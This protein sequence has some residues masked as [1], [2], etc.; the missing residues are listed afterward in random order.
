MGSNDDP[1]MCC[2][3]NIIKLLCKNII[4]KWINKKVVKSLDDFHKK[5][6]GELLSKL[7]N[8]IVCSCVKVCWFVEILGVPFAQ[9][10]D[11][12]LSRPVPFTKERGATICAMCGR[13]S[14]GDRERCSQF[15][16]SFF[17]TEPLS[18]Y[19]S[20]NSLKATKQISHEKYSDQGNK[21]THSTHTRAN[22]SDLKCLQNV[23]FLDKRKTKNGP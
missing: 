16:N 11:G 12:P 2:V 1:R 14:R 22:S 17:D 3:I 20:C 10:G 5:E 18:Q 15:W 23:N 13:A 9:S 4:Y 21:K 7:I 8:T 19:R 6:I